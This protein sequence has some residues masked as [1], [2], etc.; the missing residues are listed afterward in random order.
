NQIQYPDPA[1]GHTQIAYDGYCLID[2]DTNATYVDESPGGPPSA[3]FGPA[4]FTQAASNQWS[5]SRNTTDGKYQLSEFIKIN[6]QP[7]SIYVAMTVKNIGAV[8]HHIAGARAV[9]PAIDG[10]AADDQYNEFGGTG[11][12]VG[13]TGQAFQA[14]PVGSNSLLFG[15]TQANSGVQ[16]WA[17]WNGCG[18]N[19]DPPGLVSGGNRVLL[20]K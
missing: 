18:G 8:V 11:T 13:R 14:A 16:S 12:G 10:N 3:G 9:A 7:R 4:T 15:P 1:T 2:T 20:G 17:N 19:P 6:F 5:M